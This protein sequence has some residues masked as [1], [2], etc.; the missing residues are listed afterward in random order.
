MGTISEP[1]EQSEPITC[2]SEIVPPRVEF[3]AGM[4]DTVVVKAGDN[5]KLEAAISGIFLFLLMH[6]LYLH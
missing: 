2:K 5:V 4:R 3:D 1:S 6:Y